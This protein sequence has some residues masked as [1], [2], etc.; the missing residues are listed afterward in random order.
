MS[1]CMMC[2][3]YKIKQEENGFSIV[4]FL[5]TSTYSLKNNNTM[6]CTIY[7]T[8]EKTVF[9]ELAKIDSMSGCTRMHLLSFVVSLLTTNF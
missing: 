2:G 8:S 3:L 5:Y 9:S 7:Y 1:M 6:D 4:K